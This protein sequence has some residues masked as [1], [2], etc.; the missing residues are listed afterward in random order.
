MKQTETQLKPH[1]NNVKY[2]RESRSLYWCFTPCNFLALTHHIINNDCILPKHFRHTLRATANLFVHGGHKHIFDKDK[3]V[4][5]IIDMD[6]RN[7][8]QV[9]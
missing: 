9:S 6:E 5:L 7:V 4:R 2:K 8:D 1:F 3:S